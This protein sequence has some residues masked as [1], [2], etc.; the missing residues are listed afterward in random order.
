V[1]FQIRVV[2]YG[3]I[4]ATLLAAELGQDGIE[5]A[6]ITVSRGQKPLGARVYRYRPNGVMN[7]VRW[8]SDSHRGTLW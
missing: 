4:D 6:V 7:V 1:M 8:R 2:M 3:V 5:P